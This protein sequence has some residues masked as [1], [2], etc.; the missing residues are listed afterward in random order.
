MKKTIFAIAALLFTF[1]GLCQKKERQI[2]PGLFV[3]IP[4]EISK[5]RGYA[6]N[7]MSFGAGAW[8]GEKTPFTSIGVFF[9]ITSF[10]SISDRT[11]IIQKPTLSVIIDIHNKSKLFI[12]PTFTVG[13]NDYFDIG[14]KL[15]YAMDKEKSM[16]ITAFASENLRFGIGAVAKI[17]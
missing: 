16:Y 2:N 8:F 15:G 11:S 1:S 4:M 10:Q 12:A 17:K 13:S 3:D 5:T 6:L 9:G 14:F 7:G